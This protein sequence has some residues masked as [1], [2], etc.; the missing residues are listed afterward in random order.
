VKI[1]KWRSSNR[2]AY[3]TERTRSMYK[4]T[5]EVWPDS[6]RDVVYVKIR[7]RSDSIDQEDK[8][9]LVFE[10]SVELLETIPETARYPNRSGEVTCLGLCTCEMND[11]LRYGCRCRGT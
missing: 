9:G 10:V 2:L 1:T 11:L 8:A 5:S 4:F 6:M 7:R 3:I